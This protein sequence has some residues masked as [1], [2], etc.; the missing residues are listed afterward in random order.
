MHAPEPTLAAA[1]PADPELEALP[2]P[3][4]PGRWLSLATMG[5]T[6]LVAGLLAWSLR[7]EAAYATRGAEPVEVADLGAASPARELAN[8]WV[9]A[10]AL[11]GASGAVR[12]KRP[13]HS[14]SFRLAPVAGN[15]AI[16]IEVRVPDGME[17]PRFVPPS[18]FVGRL[19][20]FD[21]AGLRHAALPGLVHD[22]TGATVPAGAWLLVDGES[23]RELRWSLA[24]AALLLGVA[25]FNVWG[26]V[27]LVRPVRDT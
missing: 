19:V 12:Y 17:G 20:P 7:H 9:S 1:E 13:A 23:P 24:L 10:D 16:W 6:T 15:E 26:I 27:R 2:E 18:S 21:E 3:R 5:A 8:A 14:D 22:V 25:A 4:R 11:L